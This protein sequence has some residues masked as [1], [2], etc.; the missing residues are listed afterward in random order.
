MKVTNTFYTSYGGEERQ[1]FWIMESM[2]DVTPAGAG[3]WPKR[4]TAAG[5]EQTCLLEMLLG[6]ILHKAVEFECWM[7]EVITE[8]SNGEDCGVT[9]CEEDVQQEMKQHCVI[10]ECLEMER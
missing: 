7:T 1:K 5:K 4:V 10:A 6:N 3:E 9:A 8:L 2:E